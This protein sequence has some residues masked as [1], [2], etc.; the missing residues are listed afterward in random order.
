[1]HWKSCDKI[2]SPLNVY[3]QQFYGIATKPEYSSAICYEV[4]PEGEV[5]LKLVW[6]LS[7]HWAARRVAIARKIS[8]LRSRFSN[9]FLTTCIILLNQ[10]SCFFAAPYGCQWQKSR[11]VMTFL[12][13]GWCIGIIWVRNARL[14]FS[15]ANDSQIGSLVF[16][17]LVNI[18]L[19]ICNFCFIKNSDVRD[20]GNDSWDM[21]EGR[22]EV[23]RA[24]RLS[25]NTYQSRA[26][27]AAWLLYTYLT[28]L[29]KFFCL[30][31]PPFRIPTSVKKKYVYLLI[32]SF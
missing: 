12:K 17:G 10:I 5:K 9:C 21:G 23:W 28:N 7:M 2:L 13:L 1:M 31:V 18:S 26:G 19:D 25:Y 11:A 22:R 30:L 14:N 24:G 32:N 27:A 4:S 6:L 3:G 29:S 15:Y 16:I 20:C 8:A